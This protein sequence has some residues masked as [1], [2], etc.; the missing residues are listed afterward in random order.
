MLALGDYFPAGLG[1][2]VIYNLNKVHHGP[3]SG[4]FVRPSA[5]HGQRNLRTSGSGIEPGLGGREE[6]KL[7]R[8]SGAQPFLIIL[9]G[10]FALDLL[11]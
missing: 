3:V 8:K 9:Y 6:P 7:S 1:K 11:C 2:F 10:G 4:D 5:L